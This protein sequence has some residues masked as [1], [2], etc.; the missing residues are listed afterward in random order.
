MK[1]SAV[2]ILIFSLLFVFGSIGL[3]K[4][5]AG[6]GSSGAILKTAP[7]YYGNVQQ[8]GNEPRRGGCSCCSGKQAQ[9][10]QESPE[11][12]AEKMAFEYYALRYG[13]RDITVEIRDFG[14]HMEAYIK[15]GQAVVRKLSIS[16]NNIFEIG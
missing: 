10:G 9:G 13:D 8:P 4:Y 7:Q 14:C 3:A 1:K 11:K 5:W 6:N 2:F 16:G 15:K 12:Y